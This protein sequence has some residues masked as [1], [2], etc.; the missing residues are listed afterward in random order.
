MAKENNAI[1][2]FDHGE[3]FFSI[4]TASSVIH[5]F[6]FEDERYKNVKNA[7]SRL[8][9]EKISH[10]KL[11]ILL[12]FSSYVV[13]KRKYPGVPR[14]KVESTLLCDLS[15]RLGTD[16][17]D[18][19]LQV[20]SSI[21]TDK[22][23]LDE[24]IFVVV[25]KKKLLDEIKQ[26]LILYN[27][28]Q[29]SYHLWLI[30]PEV[31]LSK[32]FSATESP[33]SVNNLSLILYWQA[34]QA[35]ALLFKKG[36]MIEYY[37]IPGIF[38][39]TNENSEEFI[40]LTITINNI[41]QSIQRKH[42]TKH[43]KIY[44]HHEYI[45]LPDTIIQYLQKETALQCES[46]KNIIKL[47]HTKWHCQKSIAIPDLLLDNY[48]ILSKDMSAMPAF[49]LMKNYLPV[50]YQ[51]FFYH[52]FYTMVIFFAL[53]CV[54]NIYHIYQIYR[55][56]LQLS[57]LA[58]QPTSPIK[59]NGLYLD[60]KYQPLT[61]GFN[62][63]FYEIVKNPVPNLWLSRIQFKRTADEKS[64]DLNFLFEGYANKSIAIQEF[65]QNLKELS[66]NLN[67]RKTNILISY[68]PAP[69]SNQSDN[70][71]NSRDSNEDDKNPT[72]TNVLKFSIK[73]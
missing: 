14:S 13:Y 24:D 35:K 16:P 29:S 10:T 18:L 6:I 62:K 3:T 40:V 8:F 36:Q 38:H 61:I 58:K 1:V 43:V 49:N 51:R 55:I 9:L 69:S 70:L 25:I 56:N 57:Q 41:V 47:P 12:D 2:R 39:T 60:K 27:L 11:A 17:N 66:F 45:S 21:D 32:L 34:G 73:N 42:N 7:E 31:I 53:L 30:V 54:I 64:N 22:N 48:Y 72:L 20:L 19:C 50:N 44:Y 23:Q 37:R 68:V 71:F 4:Q 5:E 52:A 59:I 15:T 46:L 67:N 65:V 26:K 33:A 63:I 28:F